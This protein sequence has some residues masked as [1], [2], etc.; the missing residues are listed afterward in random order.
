MAKQMLAEIVIGQAVKDVERNLAEK[1]ADN[2]D[3]AK[4]EKVKGVPDLA[5]KKE[6]KGK[7]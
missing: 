3:G 2:A 6:P 1:I 4:E 7:I 5:S